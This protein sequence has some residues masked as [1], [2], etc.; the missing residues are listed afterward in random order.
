[1]ADHGKSKQ[2]TRDIWG[3][4]LVGLMIK[5]S[6]QKAKQG[7]LGIHLALCSDLEVALKD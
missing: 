4:K 7:R 5:F 6:R 1:M 2:T 3:K